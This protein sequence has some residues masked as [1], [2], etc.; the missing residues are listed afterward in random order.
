MIANALMR[1]KAGKA[2]EY[3]KYK[4]FSNICSLLLDGAMVQ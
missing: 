2:A 4:G 1:V 3:G